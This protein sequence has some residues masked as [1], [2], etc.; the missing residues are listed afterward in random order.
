MAKLRIVQ[1][2]VTAPAIASSAMK[3]RRLKNRPLDAA[4]EAALQQGLD[5]AP[6][7][8][9]KRSLLRLGREVL[10]RQGDD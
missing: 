2:R 8:P 7:G 10:R 4:A 1:G 3:A 9:L 6:D 5:R